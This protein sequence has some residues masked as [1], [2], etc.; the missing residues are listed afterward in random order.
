M[1][2]GRSISRFSTEPS[3][4]TTTTSERSGRQ[5]DELD[6]AERRLFLGRDDH[7]R[8]ARQARQQA[9]RLADQIVE[10]VAGL[11]AF[12]LDG[13]TLVG[14]QI[15]D[16]QEGI[17]IEPETGLG[18]QAPGAG[19]GRVQQADVFQV[20]HHVAHRGRRQR[21]REPPRNRARA[22]G[23]AGLDVFVD[24]NAENFPRSLVKFL[25]HKPSLCPRPGLCWLDRR[26]AVHVGRA[27][28][29]VNVA[30]FWPCW[31][32]PPA[33]NRKAVPSGID[34]L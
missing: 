28:P 16:L 26:G 24:D 27:G 6:L 14:R 22:D 13:Q 9:R 2:G 11:A 8:V 5:R 18:R 31:L 25:D 20:R 34:P 17:D 33:G 1:P 21:G 7:A 23:F 32:L 10:Q 15:A 3:S 4:C 29:T 19:M 30:P 12:L